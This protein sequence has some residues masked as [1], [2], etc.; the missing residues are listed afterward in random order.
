MTEKTTDRMHRPAVRG[1]PR[2]PR[3]DHRDPPQLRR[4]APTSAAAAPPHPSYFLKPSSSVAA[5]GGTIERPAGHRAARLRGRDR[6]RHRHR[7]RGGSP[8]PTRGTTSR[9]VTAANDF[10]LY[11]LRAND[12]GSNVRSKGGDGFTPIGPALIDARAV[13]PARPAAAHLGQR[14]AR[15]RTT[16]PP[17]C[18]SRSPSSSPTSRS[19]SRSSRATSSS[20]ARPPARRSSC[21]GDVVEVEVDAPTRPGAPSTGR[22]V[23][24][25]D[26]GRGIRSIPPSGRSPRS[27]TCSAPR[28]G[29]RRD[30]RRGAATRR[31]RPHRRS[32]ATS[33]CAPRSPGSAR[34]CASAG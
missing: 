31:S 13:D 30:G 17:A 9:W 28:R 4:R 6:A 5:S 19:T 24:T 26:A 29:A 32:C 7:P 8:S 21:P 1:T 18:S 14:R 11:D 12:K 33:S 2:A 25:V 27:T 34:S 3:Q 22:L 10:G 15:A 20:P 16:R 23:T